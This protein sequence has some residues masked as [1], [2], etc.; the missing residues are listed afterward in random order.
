MQS[1][2]M[3]R[4]PVE[5]LALAGVLAVASAQAAAVGPVPPA[6]HTLSR[7]LLQ[8]T[9]AATAA[10]TAAKPVLM[11]DVSGAMLAPY[12][13]NITGTCQTI[14]CT[15]NGTPVPA[16]HRRI[17]ESVNCMMYL[18]GAN[19]QVGSMILY[20]GQD[21]TRLFLP[22]ALAGSL[23]VANVPTSLSFEAGDIPYVY[24]YFPAGT[25]IQTECNLVGREM[26]V[27]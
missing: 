6:T 13:E 17:V 2:A 8:A 3:F 20:S 12:K 25:A 9:P 23:W 11:E 24:F 10:A 1:L 27:N 15:I 7:A 5:R 26:A 19:Q 14:A 16:G 18:N 4:L 22:F 21:P